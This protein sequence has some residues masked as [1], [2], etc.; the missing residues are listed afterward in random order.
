MTMCLLQATHQVQLLEQK[1]SQ[2]M[3]ERDSMASTVEAKE[4]Q[5]LGLQAQVD[6]LRNHG[7]ETEAWLT[8]M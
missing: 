8:S 2:L 1:I 7:C 4:S 5:L 3:S 6:L